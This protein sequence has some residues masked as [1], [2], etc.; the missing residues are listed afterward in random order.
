MK[1][2]C[3]FDFKDKEI[4]FDTENKFSGN[5]YLLECLVDDFINVPTENQDLYFYVNYGDG[6]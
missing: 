5:D 4:Y 2:I 1:H 6:V 3:R